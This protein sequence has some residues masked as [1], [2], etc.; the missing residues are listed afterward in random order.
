[1]DDTAFSPAD[2]P[3]TD[4]DPSTGSGPGTQPGPIASAGRPGGAQEGSANVSDA[5][6]SRP[7]EY[8][9]AELAA[10]A[11][12]EAGRIARYLRESGLEVEQK[13][14]VS[15]VVTEA[16]RA[17]EESITSLL[18]RHRPDDGILGEEGTLVETDSDRRW[19]VDPVDGTYNFVSG[20]D[21]WCSAVALSGPDEYLLGAIHRPATGETWIGGTESGARRGA[22][23]LPRLEP[24]GLA[25]G[26]LATYLH[27]PFLSDPD[28]AEPF[29]R[30]SQ[31]AAT[32]RMLGSGS[33]DL[34][35]VAEGKYSVWCQHSCP[36]WDWLPGKAIVEAAGGRTAVVEV[37]GYD[38][39]VAGR[40]GAVEQAVALLSGK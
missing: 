22:V 2:A 16:D 36:E 28:L 10:L 17:A 31:G 4:A 12:Q 7:I 30:V 21:Y 27:P 18:G 33:L 23:P 38:W 26:C 1:M 29:R 32:M 25:D 14:S 35:A 34:A 24:G 19:A 6:R 8:D 20:S 9:D 13:T 39:F 5:G 40:P 37:A 11:V 3:A 15:D